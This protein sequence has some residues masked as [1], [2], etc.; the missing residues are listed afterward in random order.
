[1]NELVKTLDDLNVKDED[2]LHLSYKEEVNVNHH[3][4]NYQIDAIEITTVAHRLADLLATK[5]IKVTTEY[6]TSIVENMR[7][8]GFLDLYEH[9]YTF[10]YYLTDVLIREG[11]Q[12]GYLDIATKKLD[13]KRGIA[14]VAASVKIPVAQIRTLGPA[15]DDLTSDWDV[16]IERNNRI[17]ILSQ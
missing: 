17:L 6:G 8:E 10:S 9:D 16:S 5:G 2:Y 12:Y 4:D 15:A 1:M 11:Y 14:T 3:I 13:N 7:D